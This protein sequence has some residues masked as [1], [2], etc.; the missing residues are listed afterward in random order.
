VYVRVSLNNLYD[1]VARIT[2]IFENSVMSKSFNE[3]LMQ[4][5]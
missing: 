3:D 5:T 1:T 4:G 2:H